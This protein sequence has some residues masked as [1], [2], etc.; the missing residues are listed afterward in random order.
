MGLR[1][2][3]DLDEQWPLPR[4]SILQITFQLARILDTNCRASAG[5]CDLDVIDGREMASRREATE[6]R[7]LGIPLKAQNAVIEKDDDDRQF[8]PHHRFDFRPAMR[9][10]TIADESNNGLARQSSLCPQRQRQPPSQSGKSTRR[11][12]SHSRSKGAQ[13]TGHPHR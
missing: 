5:L 13:L 9:E 7:S 4:Q 1:V 2:C 3:H 8:G 11:K 10:P 6:L 12:K